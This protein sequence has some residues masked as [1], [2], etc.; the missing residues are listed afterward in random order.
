MRKHRTPDIILRGL[1]CAL[2]FLRAADLWARPTTPQEAQ[3][4]VAGWLTGN[5]E[6][7]DVRLGHRVGG[8]R[9]VMDESGAPIYYIV[10]LVP[11][12]F[13]IVPADDLIEPILSFTDAPTYEPSP[14]DPLTALVTA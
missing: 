2:L 3:L 14:W 1:I 12:G 10:P 11:S 6:P 5:A 13:V 8:V 9:T 4:A 7:L